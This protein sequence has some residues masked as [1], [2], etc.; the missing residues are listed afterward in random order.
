MKYC[1]PEKGFS[2]KSEVRGYGLYALKKMVDQSSRLILETCINNDL[3]L[4][5]MIVELN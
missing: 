5:D 1:K 2:N 3:S 4:L